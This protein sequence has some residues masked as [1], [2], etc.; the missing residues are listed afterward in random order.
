MLEEFSI[1]FHNFYN[2]LIQLEIHALVGFF[3]C[4]FT[5]TIRIHFLVMLEIKKKKKII[6]SE[7]K[8]A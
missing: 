3:M 5:R 4:S 6:M 7:I 2:F 8:V 1:K